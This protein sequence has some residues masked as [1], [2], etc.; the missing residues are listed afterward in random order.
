MT[1]NRGGHPEPGGLTRISVR[2]SSNCF[3]VRVGDAPAVKVR[4][5]GRNLECEC[6]RPGCQHITSLRMCGFVDAVGEMPLAA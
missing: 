6:Q 5:S 4:R 3:F 2:S 1:D